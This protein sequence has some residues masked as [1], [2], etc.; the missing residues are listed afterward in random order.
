MRRLPNWRTVGYSTGGQ[1]DSTEGRATF[2]VF[3]LAGFLVSTWLL[4]LVDTPPAQAVACNHYNVLAYGS[5]G[6][7]FGT[8]AA[9]GIWVPTATQNPTCA[10]ISSLI[11][12][13]VDANR[14]FE[15]GW[16]EQP[17]ESAVGCNYPSSS[18]AP[19]LFVWSWLGSGGYC[20]YPSGTPPI[21]TG[22]NPG[23]FEP[24]S[25]REPDASGCSPQTAEWKFNENGKN[26]TSGFSTF[27]VGW[28]LANG[29]R[30]SS[31][32][33]AHS[34]FKG[35][36][37]YGASGSWHDWPINSNALWC[38]TDSDFDRSSYADDTHSSVDRTDSGWTG[39][40]QC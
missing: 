29:E 15:L 1:F 32:D 37:Y 36:A 11:V 38:D 26:L 8:K 18:T 9:T 23:S 31:A 17:G 6:T 13:N 19:R 28:G 10:R 39:G 7:H 12:H 35:L 25:I 33:N 21:V 2:V 30:H 4:Q 40:S 34:E 3:A 20:F 22:S 5:D 14:G 27:C 16:Y 24:F